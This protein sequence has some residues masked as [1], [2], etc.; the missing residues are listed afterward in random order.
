[1][2]QAEYARHR[3]KSRQYISRLAKA[4]VLVLRG[5]K[6]DVA[7]SDAVLE[8]RPEPVS[9]RVVAGP[10][11]ATPQGTTFAQARTADMVF[12]AKLRKLEHDV[13][14]G[15]LVEA[16]LV[17]QRWAAIYVAIKERILAWPNRVAP[18][19]TPL[20][21]ERQVRDTMMREARTLI[22]DIKADVQYAR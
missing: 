3:G 1:M 11:E 4:G 14:V 6:V 7:A 17:K 9:E 15:K 13:R 16:E 2:S 21:D 8:D 18:E 22:N 19:I 12:R 20:T 5:G 10:T